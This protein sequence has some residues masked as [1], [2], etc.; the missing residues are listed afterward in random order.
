MPTTPLFVLPLDVCRV[1]FPA[2]SETLNCRATSPRLVYI[3][4]IPHFLL[5]AIRTIVLCRAAS[6]SLRTLV[7]CSPQRRLRILLQVAAA[8]TIAQVQQVRNFASCMPFLV[9]RFSSWNTLPHRYTSCSTLC[10]HASIRSTRAL[11]CT[12]ESPPSRVL[13]LL[14]TCIARPLCI[15]G[16]ASCHVSCFAR[17][18]R[19]RVVP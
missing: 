6:M 15:D 16:A 8:L 1:L 9:R 7:V 10:Q 11:F 3:V 5:T 4:R 2:L 12:L 13:R 19:G 14:C 17:Q 18:L